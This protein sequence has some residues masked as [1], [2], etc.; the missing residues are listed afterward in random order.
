MEE[1]K[2]IVSKTTMFKK[3]VGKLMTLIYDNEVF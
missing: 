1:G 2:R 3:M